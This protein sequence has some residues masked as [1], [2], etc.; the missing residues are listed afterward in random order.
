MAVDTRSPAREGRSST[1]RG[2]VRGGP[3]ARRGRE[4]PR[5][6]LLASASL[7]GAFLAAA[8]GLGALLDGLSW[9][10]VVSLVVLIVLGAAALTRAR[11]RVAALAP[12]V[13]A[14]VFVVVTTLFFAPGSAILG[15]I[16]TPDTIAVWRALADAAQTSISEQ[17]VPA[18]ANVAIVFAA[19]V[20]IGALAWVGD[21]VAIT[22]RRPLFV[23]VPL[24]VILAIPPV[25]APGRFDIASF[26]AT[27]AAFLAL[28]VVVRGTRQPGVAVG[29]GAVAV[30]GSLLTPLVLPAVQPSVAFGPGLSTGINPVLN[31]GDD[32]RRTTDRTVLEYSTE[33]G[34]A[35]YLRLVTLE[36][37]TGDEWAPT[38]TRVDTGNTLDD[39]GAIP[40]LESEVPLEPE[41]TAIDVARLSSPWLP[42]PYPALSVSG[43]EGE[44][45]FEPRGLSASGVGETATGL[46]YTVSSVRVT[47]TPEQLLAAVPGTDDVD[48]YLE[49][50]DDLPEV[51]GETARTVAGD[52]GAYTS[53]IRLQEFFRSGDFDYSETAPVDN[54]YDGTGMEVIATFLEARSGYCVHFSSAMAVMARELGIPARVVVGF[55]P[56][57]TGEEPGI[58]E[59]S[60]HDLHAWP[61]LYFDGIGWVQFEPTPGRGALETYAD[62]S[63]EG[64]PEATPPAEAEPDEPDDAPDPDVDPDDGTDPET[65]QDPDSALPETG[66]TE[67]AQ[68]PQGGL[69][70]VGVAALILGLA[71]APALIRFGQRAA[72]VRRARDGRSDA[73]EAWREVVR[74]ATDTGVALVDTATPREN[75]RL[76]EEA[77]LSA[78]PALSRVLA[79]VERHAFAGATAA[80]AAGAGA[81]GDA[82]GDVAAVR[83]ALLTSAGAGGA[84]RATVL[85]RSLLRAFD[86]GRTTRS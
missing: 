17:T 67:S 69:A 31:L 15:I 28:L 71:L 8:F 85:P 70:W 77:L 9:W 20:G 34:S 6:T 10:A 75:A 84:L 18:T 81:E 55:L 59:V 49:L 72:F 60:T 51:I 80:A 30:V 79:R 37:F 11:A 78:E 5:S 24:L 19:S 39:F 45:F 33:S 53:A 46:D 66:S 52:D 36:R 86:R 25:V 38:P 40:G 74:D 61:E 12:I 22:L 82:P 29:I 64:V 63:I 4:K 7:A 27:S 48:D 13:S 14:V 65:D 62:V 16:P 56:G 58:F 44:W 26:V 68:T 32:L 1:A 43:V 54:G 76:I 23:A 3:R 42:L 47:P 83:S 50:P 35:Q 73:V 2:P 41:T 57:S 21:V